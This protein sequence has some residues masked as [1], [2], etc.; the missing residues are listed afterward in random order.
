MRYVPID[1]VEPGQFL[2]KTIFS[3]NGSI[4][5]SENVQLT[6][7]MINTLKRIGVTMLYIKDENFDDVDILRSGFRR[8]QTRHYT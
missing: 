4:L 7:Y 5:L 3:G 2:G 8:D 6:V 1:A